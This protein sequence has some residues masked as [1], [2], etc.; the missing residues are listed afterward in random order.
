MSSRRFTEARKYCLTSSG[1]ILWKL[2]IRSRKFKAK[3]NIINAMVKKNKQFQS[4]CNY[5]LEPII[6]IKVLFYN[7][8]PE[9]EKQKFITFLATHRLHHESKYDSFLTLLKDKKKLT[10]LIAKYMDYFKKREDIP[11]CINRRA[12]MNLFPENAIRSIKELL[13]KNIGK[14]QKSLQMKNLFYE[15]AKG[16]IHSNIYVIES[17]IKQLNQTSSTAAA[18]SANVS[19]A[20]D[21]A[22]TERPVK[23]EPLNQSFLSPGASTSAFHW[24]LFAIT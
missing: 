18:A 2:Y 21:A 24:R 20:A 4:G 10:S 6:M 16:V 3:E 14:Y 7:N 1:K 8:L 15:S 5:R 19:A 23:L 11:D 22:D 17:E 9:A 13:K 12:F